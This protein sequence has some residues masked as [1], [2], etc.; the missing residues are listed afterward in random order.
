MSNAVSANDN[1]QD[2]LRRNVQ[3]YLGDEVSMVE[4]D[5][6]PVR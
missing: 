2:E 4:M 6:Q 5:Y 1:M 3:H